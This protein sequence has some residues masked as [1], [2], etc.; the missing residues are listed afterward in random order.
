MHVEMA[1]EGMCWSLLGSCINRPGFCAPF[2]VGKGD[3]LD[4]GTCSKAGESVGTFLCQHRAEK[5]EATH[6]LDALI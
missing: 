6:G 4:Q 5:E 2:L 3:A 1:D